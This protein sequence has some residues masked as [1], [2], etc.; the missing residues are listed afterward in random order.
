MLGRMPPRRSAR[1]QATDRPGTRDLLLEVAGQVFAEH[2]F[3][4]ATGKEICARAGTNTAAINYYFGSMDG[5]HAAVLE[6]AHSRFFTLDKVRAALA[7]KL[8]ARAKLEALLGLVVEGLAGPAASGW[9]VRVMGREVAAPSP[10]FAALRVR[11]FL[12]K[13]AILKG[14][15]G[16]LMGLPVDHPAVARGCLSIMGPCVTLAVADHALLGQAFPALGLGADGIAALRDH[17]V[18]YALAGLATIAAAEK[19][20]KA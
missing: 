5:L 17:M 13:I 8:D 3:D 2:G 10:A 19:A 16:E 9:A 11:E 4:R 20:G 1:T 15:V 6:E 12:P 14:I 7:G 18:R